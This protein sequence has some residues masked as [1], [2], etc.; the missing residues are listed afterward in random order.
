[1]AESEK[2]IL[3]AREKIQFYHA[4]MQELVGISSVFIDTI[5][6][7]FLNASLVSFL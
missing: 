5:H 2:E 1:M 7:K 4:K 3:D 6:I